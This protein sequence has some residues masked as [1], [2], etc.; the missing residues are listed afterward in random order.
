MEVYF[1][2]HGTTDWNAERRFQGEKDIEL[3]E[4]GRELA[5]TLGRRLENVHFDRIY[6]SPLIRAYE[7]ACLI[8]GHRNIPIIRDQRLR[9]LSFGG[10]EGMP[11]TQWIDTDHPRKYFFTEPGRYQPPEGGETLQHVCD[12]TRDFAQSELE[13]LACDGKTERVMVVAHGALLAALMCYLEG[14]GVENFWGSG[15]KG[16]CEETVFSFDGSVWKKLTDDE[17]PRTNPY[18]SAAKNEKKD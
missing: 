16:N 2:R 15:L 10:L 9:E 8:R 7:T 1:I 5:G 6:S 3:N 18:E 11:Y 14:H 4:N 12:R 17:G 13:K